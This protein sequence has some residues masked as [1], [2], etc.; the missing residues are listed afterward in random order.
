VPEES[1]GTGTTKA[2]RGTIRSLFRRR[3]TER[4]GALALT[5]RRRLSRDLN[6]VTSK[7]VVPLTEVAPPRH[8]RNVAPTRADVIILDDGGALVVRHVTVSETRMP[9]G[10][11]NEALD[12]RRRIRAVTPP[13]PV[14]LSDSFP[15][16]DL[17]TQPEVAALAAVF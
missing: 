2:G 13:P 17:R 4:Q 11:E 9:G 10:C 1:A 16:L 15:V 5:V 12:L 14:R 6:H 3:A 7:S 8:E